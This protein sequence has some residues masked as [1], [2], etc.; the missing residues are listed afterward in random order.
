MS[1]RGVT[2]IELIIV[3]VAM[4]AGLAL[5]GSAF[6]EPARSVIDNQNIQQAWQVA[7]GCGDFTL[8]RA[9]TPGQFSNV[10]VGMADPC[11]AAPAGATRTFTVAPMAAGTEP[12]AGATWTCRKVTITVTI[13]A[14][15]A[16]VNFM[17]VNS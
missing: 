4:T 15:T 3:I 12:C 14:Y 9:Q 13:G 6:I 10:T 5:I 7:Q 16:S 17:I 11:P 8:G 1:Q 2:L